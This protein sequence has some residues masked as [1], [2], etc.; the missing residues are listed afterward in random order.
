MICLI[1]LLLENNYKKQIKNKIMR[2][3][4][5]YVTRKYAFVKKGVIFDIK[6]DSNSDS[7]AVEINSDNAPYIEVNE[8]EGVVS[9]FNYYLDS[10]IEDGDSYTPIQEGDEGE[11]FKKTMHANEQCD[12][13]EI[14][15]QD[16]YRDLCLEQITDVIVYNYTLDYNYY[17]DHLG[18]FGIPMFMFKG[19]GGNVT[20]PTKTSSGDDYEINFNEDLYNSLKQ[21]RIRKLSLNAAEET[22]NHYNYHVTDGAKSCFAVDKNNNQ[23]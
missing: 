12:E 1:Y 4:N 2:T 5:T 14:T 11:F 20:Y 18:D 3:L 19:R 8:G 17:K 21:E 22:A 7:C 16:Y 23:G 10:Y 13:T 6:L 15:F 9:K